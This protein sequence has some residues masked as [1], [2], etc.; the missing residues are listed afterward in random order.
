MDNRYEIQE[1]IGRG[2]MAVVYKAMCHRLNRLVAVKILK[3]EYSKDAEFRRRFHAESQ[4]VAM[5]SHP[6]IVGVYDVSH[7]DDCD[8]IVMELIDGIT[9]KQYLEQKG[10]LSWREVLHFAPQI[11]KAIEHAHSKG[12][13]HRDIKPHNIMVLKDGSVKVADFGIARMMS[14]QSTLT[15][16]ALGSVH[17]ISPEQAKGGKVDCRT[18]LYSLGVV[19][20]EML[21]GKPPFDGETPVSV[22]IQHIH[23]K[24]TPLRTI[25]PSIPE[26][27]VQIVMRA[28]CTDLN[29]RY[30]S[31]T[32]MLEDLERFR[33]DPS[34]LFE[35]PK[36]ESAPAQEETAE[37]EQK[38]EPIRR[39]ERKPKKKP[40]RTTIL[41]FV[42]GILLA[43]TGLTALVSYLLRDVFR[44]GEE[45][46]VPD[47]QETSVDALK[48]LYG[49]QFTFEIGE[50]VF[51]DKIPYGYV[52][53]QEPKPKKSVKSGSTITVTASLG[54]KKMSM[55]N[56]VNYSVADAQSILSSFDVQVTVTYEENDI[57]VQD[58]VIRTSPTYGEPLSQGQQVELIVS[59]GTNAKL[60]EV[61]ELT[62]M[63]VEEAL[64]LLDELE[65]GKGN[66]KYVENELPKGT[67]TFQSIKQGTEVKEGTVINLQVSQGSAQKTQ[68]PSIEIQPGSVTVEQGTT[69]VLSVAASV[70]DGGTLSYEWFC[71]E[72]GTATNMQSVGTGV[73]LVV[74]TSAI[75]SKSYCCK[76]TNTLGDN[77][78]SIYSNMAKVTV[79]EEETAVTKTITLPLPAGDGE[80]TILI[81]LDGANYMTPFTV[82]RSEGSIEIDVEAYGEHVVDVYVDGLLSLSRTMDFS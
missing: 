52:V 65:L 14:A 55:P 73:S 49:D 20:Y 2:G 34:V 62:G 3:D 58:Y 21:A 80:A 70:S 26:G 1:V 63:D 77:P 17:Y 69:T 25:N 24:P 45:V 35:E 42:L 8:Y 12:V 22:A 29:E 11:C 46:R 31:A 74:D 57:Y 5:L 43:V 44:S 32:Q 71:S 30:Q 79:T 50:W 9:L 76:I 47:L 48:S 15:R 67:V 72:T 59:K 4:A 54:S 36:K 27:L 6:N 40:S 68:I 41:A 28:M 38:R 82:D 61:P 10:T 81:K 13:I 78:V 60:C 66:I 23:S 56:L 18:D 39:T 33:Q 75:G 64:A 19:M 16:E 37:P 51:D 7:T 53:S